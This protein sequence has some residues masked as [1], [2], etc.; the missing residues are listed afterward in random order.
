MPLFERGF[1]E[2]VMGELPTNH[3]FTMILSNEN[4]TSVP[5]PFCSQFVNFYPPY[6]PLN[7]SC[8]LILANHRAPTGEEKVIY[9]FLAFNII[10]GSHRT[11]D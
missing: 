3:C 7:P 1:G 11:G 10:G 9:I 5:T 6:F 2:N 4:N 8:F